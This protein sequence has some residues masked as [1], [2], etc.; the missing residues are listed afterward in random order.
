MNNAAMNIYIHVFVQI[1]IFSFL[2]YIPRSRIP[3]SYGNS[4]FN[5]LCRKG[6]FPG[7]VSLFLF[8][9]YVGL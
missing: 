1:Y 4:I 7:F 6:M 8:L 9:F 2:G 5:F 3:E